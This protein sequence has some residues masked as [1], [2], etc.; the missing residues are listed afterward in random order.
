MFNNPRNSMGPIEA[1]QMIEMVKEWTKDTEDKI[2]DGIKKKSEKDKEE[3]A[4]LNWTKIVRMTI[5]TVTFGPWIVL[6]Q[7]YGL[8]MAFAK[9]FKGG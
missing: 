1:I 2:K 8:T 5:W 6:I 4:Q 7:Y 3:A 9:L